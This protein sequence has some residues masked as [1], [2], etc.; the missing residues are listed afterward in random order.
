[1]KANSILYVTF[2]DFIISNSQ[3]VLSET[4]TNQCNSEEVDPRIV[5]HVIYLGKKGYTNLPVKAVDSDVVI[6]CLT[7]ADIAMSNGIESFLVVYGPKGNKSDIIDNLNMFSINV[8]KGLPFFHAFTGWNTVSSFYKVGKAKFWAVRLAK[9]KAGDNIVKYLYK[10][11]SNCPINIEV[12][13]FDMLCNFVYEAYG[14]IKQAPLKTRRTDRL[15]STPNVNLRM[16]VP[17]PSG[18]LQHTKRACIQVGY[19]WKL[20]E[21]ETNIPDPIKW[22]WKP[23]P[24]GSLAPHWQDEVVTDNSKPIIESCSCSKG[25]CSNCS[26]KKSSMKYLVY[27]KCDKGKCKNK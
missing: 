19:F 10:K 11:F 18:V 27:C 4:E 8:C 26:C 23:L 15:I 24:D 6:L 20:S 14:L 16:L 2:G 21:I 25:K 17:F 22:G 9:V 13:E 12:N 3:A 1:M 7:Y 5:R